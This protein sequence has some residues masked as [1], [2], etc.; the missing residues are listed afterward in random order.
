MPTATVN[1]DER[2]VGPAGS[3]HGPTG[4]PHSPHPPP[5]AR[6]L[7]RRLR[8]LHVAMALQGLLLW[9]PVEK[10]FMDEIGFD[11]TGVGIMAAAYAALVPVA[12]VPSGLLADR[13]SRRG[14]LVLS[15]L[16]LLVSTLVCG[17][18]NGTVAYILGAMVLG[19]YFALQSG[20][21]D[22]VVY[23]TVLEETGTSGGFEAAIGR[24]RLVN[25]MALVA[26]SVAGG[27]LAGATSARFTYFL[28]VP[29]VALS[30][31]PL[32]A[33]R[34][35]E[36]HKAD[37]EGAVGV[38]EQVAATFSALT[39]GGLLRPIV[40]L[41]VSASAVMQ[42][43]FEF[44]PLWLVAIAAPA[45]LFGPFTAGALA[46]LGLGGVLA[47]RLRFERPAMVAAVVGA[48]V[49]AGGALVVSHDAWVITVA[50]T[51]AVLLLA[52]VGVLVTRLL[53]D[54]V[55][56]SVRAGVASG[57]GAL[58]W[59]AFVPIA[60]A[61]GAVSDAHGVHAAGWIMLGL[62]AASGALLVGVARPEAGA[63][64]DGTT[65][66]TGPTAVAVPCA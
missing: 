23:D 6:R 5:C 56:S 64:A 10:L 51:V 26:G 41:T 53:H 38:R 24:V 19:A 18:S 59:V 8:P 20:T 52:A 9:L 30:V 32:L 36:L 48:M 43:V 1:H 22:S 17:L 45:A 49:V 15:S 63:P 47:P 35:P 39:R 28:T 42:L 46:A 44:G 14:V 13:W 62:L 21:L 66:A 57:V 65:A 16:A 27:W 58:S 33:F 12:E 54:A 40:A 11:A 2:P 3:P 29:I 50:Q 37:G 7:A 31:V 55:P 4:G 60:L 25:S 34:E 61:F